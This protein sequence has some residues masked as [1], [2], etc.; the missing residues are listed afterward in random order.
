MTGAFT[1]GAPMMAAMQRRYGGPDVITVG[2]APVPPPGPREVLLRVH[3]SA[4]NPADVFMM[5]GKPGLVRLTGGLTRPRQGVR[6]SDVAGEVVAVG[7]QASPWAVGDRVFGEGVGTLAEFAPARADRLAAL[8]P[9]VP[10]RDGAATVMAGLAALHALRHAGLE[11][12]GETG[13][14]ATGSRVLVIGAAG[15][16][17][18]FAVQLAARGGSDV[19]GVCSASGADAV[20]GL[21]AQRTVDYATEDVL[22]LDGPF[23]LILDNV[24][25]VPMLALERLVAPG[26]TLIPNAGI[27]GA[28]G[29]AL[30]RVAKAAWHGKVRRRRISTFYS[31]PNAKDLALLAQ[32]VADGRLT[33]LVDSTWPLAQ[34]SAALQRVAAG[35]A[36]GKVIVT[37]SAP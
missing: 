14:P 32:C 12:L 13:A 33:P 18:S 34:A 23:D 21:G 26:G 25:A 35:H 37:P 20:M 28:D 15:G 19:T 3:A 11:A 5:T 22:A 24:G 6:G 8:P 2:P 4:L 30:A 1:T 36:H 29:G 10:A 31:A 17:G 7:A 27:D 16:I 9:A